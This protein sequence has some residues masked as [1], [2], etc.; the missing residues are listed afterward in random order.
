PPPPPPPPGST[1]YTTP[2]SSWPAAGTTIPQAPPSADGTGAP[3]AL[4]AERLPPAPLPANI[5]DQVLLPCE[6]LRDTWLI[7]GIGGWSF[8]LADTDSGDKSGMYFGFDIGRTWQGC[9]GI[10]LYY[11]YSEQ[12]FDRQVTGGI[13]SDS[14]AYQ[15]LGLKATYQSSFGRASRFYWWAGLGIGWYDTDGYQ[16]DDSGFEGFGQAGLGVM[17]SRRMRLRFGVD[18]HAVDTD[19]GRF[20]PANDG[21]SRLLWMMQPVVALEYDL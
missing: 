15:H 4:P 14:G 11:R 13:L 21:S 5:R 6:V 2:S 7:R 8:A 9:F 17:L 1:T 10:D 3:R 20:D 19:T 18:V 16:I 12:S